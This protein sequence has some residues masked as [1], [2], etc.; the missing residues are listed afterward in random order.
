M[1]APW[2]VGVVV[3]HAGR[4]DPL[5]TRQGVERPGSQRRVLPH[6]LCLTWADGRFGREVIKGVGNGSDRVNEVAKRQRIPDAQRA[7]AVRRYN[8]RL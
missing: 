1:V 4:G 5:E 8:G 3:L 6:A 2:G 7:V